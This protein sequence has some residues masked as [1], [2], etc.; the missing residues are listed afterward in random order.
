MI[1]GMVFLASIFASMFAVADCSDVSDDLLE[2]RLRTLFLDH[3]AIDGRLCR[4]LEE[5]N[6]ASNRLVA[7]AKRIYE[8][9]ATDVGQKGRA[10]SVVS[11][12]G[13][14]ED[15]DFICSCATNH[16][17]WSDAAIG[18]IMLGGV[19]SESIS[20]LNS[21]MNCDVATNGVH[22]LES[23]KSYVIL[24]LMNRAKNADVPTQAKLAA[25]NFSMSFVSNHVDTI[26]IT[27]MALSRF[28]DTFQ[29]SRR[30]L[31]LL[32]FLQPRE[33]LPSLQNYVNSEI[34]K[35]ESLPEGSLVD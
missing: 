16:E 22:D 28:D 21:L 25:W 6:F 5:V 23:E 10:I 3:H 19:T 2:N 20:R 17:F 31:E 13:T 27:D 35:L 32:R 24:S 29:N 4:V 15:L 18:A 8:S 12:Y 1:K 7:V 26:M 11:S 14:S 34:G 33:T 9:E 30:R